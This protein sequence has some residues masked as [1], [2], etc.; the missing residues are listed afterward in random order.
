M[1]A[2][3][4]KTGTA[5]LADLEEQRV[6][7]RTR[8]RELR[9]ALDRLLGREGVNGRE[10]GEVDV[11][12]RKINAAKRGALRTGET[13]DVSALEVE[14][15]QLEE[16][17]AANKH[18]RGQC[19]LAERA[20]TSERRDVL[21]REHLHFAKLAVEEFVCSEELRAELARA[22]QA[23]QAQRAVVKQAVGLAAAG[24]TPDRGATLIDSFQP[25]TATKAR[26]QTEAMWSAVE[27]LATGGPQPAIIGD[28]YSIEDA[29]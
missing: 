9:V 7:V 28:D 16:R 2:T 13:A 24:V 10:G 27:A 4:T 20:I 22:A 23:V 3:K 12:K 5:Q 17:V 11:V 15:A 25:W 26:P 19:V 8:G 18:E 29:A 14:R 1:P 21:T 6:R